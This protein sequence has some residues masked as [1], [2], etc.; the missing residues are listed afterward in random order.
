MIGKKVVVTTNYRGV[1]FGTLEKREEDRAVIVN[2][3]VCI[4]WSKET[5]GFVGLAATGP[6]EGSRISRE[7]PRMEL[8]GVSAVIECSDEAA[9]GWEL[10]RWDNS[11]TS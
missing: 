7:A 2:A 8:V 1:F 6:L 10:G 11:A 9:R 4:Y 3:R 5:R